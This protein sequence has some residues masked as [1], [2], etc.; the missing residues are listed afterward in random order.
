[1]LS[2]LRRNRDRENKDE[3]RNDHFETHFCKHK[4]PFALSGEM[5]QR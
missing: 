4:A 2:L 5:R 1:M 3:D